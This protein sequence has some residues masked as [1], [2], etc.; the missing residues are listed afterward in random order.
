MKILA[1][2]DVEL[3]YLHSP[4]IKEKF[5]KISMIVS[6]GD[7]PFDYLQYIADGINAPLYYI[8]G[9]HQ[10]WLATEEGSQ[11]EMEGG[12]YL[13]ERCQVDPSGLII[14]GFSGS[15]R[16]NYG[17]HQYSQQ[18][19]WGKVLGLVPRLY[20]NKLKYGRYLDVLITHS[21]PWQINDGK[22]PPHQGFKAFRWLLS[23]F[24]PLLHLHGHVHLYRQDAS[25]V[26]QFMDTSV[27]NAYGYREIEIQIPTGR[28]PAA[29]LSYQLLR[30]GL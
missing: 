11:H 18:E 14:A 16:Y 30:K 27:M 25:F 17:S 2:S 6:C 29:R 19:M 9:N 7:L 8:L 20:S 21:S 13:N 22:D 4:A 5:P 3:A 24:R 12:I 26:T 10:F 1:V 28:K 15:L 23:N